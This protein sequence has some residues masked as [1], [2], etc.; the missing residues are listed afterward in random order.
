[1]NVA[2]ADIIRRAFASRFLPFQAGNPQEVGSQVTLKFRFVGL[3]D[4]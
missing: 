1:M 3:L 2:A 4:R